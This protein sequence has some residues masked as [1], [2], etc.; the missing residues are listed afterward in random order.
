[1]LK[2]WHWIQQLRIGLLPM[3]PHAIH[4][5]ASLESAMTSGPRKMPSIWC[6]PLSDQAAP[7]QIVGGVCQ[8]VT[9]SVG[10]VIAV[11]NVR[12]ATGDASRHD[13]EMLRDDISG[14]LLNWIPPDAEAQVTYV[15]GRL[16]R[17]EDGVIWW[18]DE[19]QTTYQL[20]KVT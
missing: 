12:D 8:L 20:R 14:A 19:Y 17:I 18:Q 2:I 7:N 4:G 10:I 16:I 15:R 9:A 3:T 1:M 5:A 6:I 11:H 13:L